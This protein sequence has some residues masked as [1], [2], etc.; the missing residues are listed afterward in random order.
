MTT[1]NLRWNR[2]QVGHMSANSGRLLRTELLSLDEVSRGAQGAAD[3]PFTLRLLRALLARLSAL[4]PGQY[5]LT[6]PP[7]GAA[8]GVWRAMPEKQQSTEV[9]PLNHLPICIRK[10]DMCNL[11]TLL[12]LRRQWRRCGGLSKR[13]A[14]QPCAAGHRG[15]SCRCPVIQQPPQWER[16]I[17]CGLRMPTAARQTPTR[18]LLIL[19]S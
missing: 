15:R 9:G 6:H 2:G 12:L 1:C 18:C 5:L 17:A 10:A 3:L 19:G 14:S 4:P 16:C 7:G 11:H 13:G 8:L